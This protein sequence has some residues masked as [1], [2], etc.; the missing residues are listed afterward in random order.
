MVQFRHDIT[1]GELMRTSRVERHAGV[2]GLH[3]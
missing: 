1:D 3:G 2:R